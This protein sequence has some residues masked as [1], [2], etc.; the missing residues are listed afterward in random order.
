MDAEDCSVGEVRPGGAR[1]QGTEVA[2]I[3]ESVSEEILSGRL[4]I[5]QKISESDLSRRLKT[6]RGSVR[7]AIRCLEGRQLVERIPNLGA[8]VRVFSPEQIIDFYRMREALEGMAARLAAANMT[9]LELRQLR[10]QLEQEGE[11]S[12]TE[13]VTSLVDD[14]HVM[15]VRGSHNAWMCSVMDANYFRLIQL[16]RRHYDWLRFGGADSYREHERIMDALERRDGDRAEAIMRRHIR[17]LRE[18]SLAALAG[19]AASNGER[20][21]AAS[22]V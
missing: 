16:W 12:R 11:R 1:R 20:R 8:R 22:L 7:E 17:G 5:G 2:R 4:R 3:C 19:Q 15:L 21:T 9:D 18:A 6:S 14:F 10:R 13:P